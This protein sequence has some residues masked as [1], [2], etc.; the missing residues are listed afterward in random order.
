MK[1]NTLMLLMLVLV[2]TVLIRLI[3]NLYTN[4]IFSNDAWPLKH[5]TEYIIRNPRLDSQILSEVYGH[6][7]KWP[8]SILESVIYIH[9]TG[10]PHE[11]FFKF[12]GVTILSIA[13]FLS[14]YLLAKEYSCNYKSCLM[15]SLA[16]SLLPSFTLYTSAYLKE[17]Y[18]HTLIPILLYLTIKRSRLKLVILSVIFSIV[19][20]MSH[21][22]ASAMSIAILGSYLYTSFVI[23]FR[24]RGKFYFRFEHILTMLFLA[25]VYTLYTIFIAKPLVTLSLSDLAV[26][27]TYVT[28]VYLA[29]LFLGG[30][31]SI[32]LISVASFLASVSIIYTITVP[33]NNLLLLFYVLPPIIS[34]AYRVR[35]DFL[36][37][38]KVAVLLPIAVLFLYI[39]TYMVE[40]LGII[41]RVLNYFVYVFIPV[42]IDIAENRRKTSITIILLLSLIT[43]LCSISSTLNYNP[44][45]FYWRYGEHDNIFKDFIDEYAVNISI[46]GDPKYS[47]MTLKIS[48][49]PMTAIKDLCRL[50]GLIV[51]S[52][53]NCVYG[54]PI[55]PVDIYR[56][57]C[58]LSKGKSIVYSS[59]YLHVFA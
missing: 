32:T 36:G 28:T 52:K 10:I 57:S 9:I 12:I 38:I 35:R 34:I 11:Y 41:H 33:T 15:A 25:I 24:S 8:L 13:M 44:Y 21:P 1:N 18:S 46:Y 49:I 7:I 39:S 26:L 59:G 48:N 3:P 43:I 45:T 31:G 53:D 42:A 30:L 23:S 17:F 51:L 37:R 58:D 27:S 19:L 20:V 2:F 5:L 6:H 55:T 29:Y 16:V 47:Y 40:A 56:I 50:Q 22:L 54:I 14:V 4:N